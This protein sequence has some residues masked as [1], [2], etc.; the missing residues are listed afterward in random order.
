LSRRKIISGIVFIVA[1]IIIITLSIASGGDG[2]SPVSSTTSYSTGK[3]GFKVF[4]LLLDKMKYRIK[5][6]TRPLGELGNKSGYTSSLLILSPYSF[7]IKKGDS[8]KLIDWAG[9][10]NRILIASKDSNDLLRALDVQVSTNG[11]SILDNPE[12]PLCNN[13]SRLEGLGIARL[14]IKKDYYDTLLKD[15]YGVIC[16]RIKYDRGEINIISAPDI[17]NNSNIKKADNVIFITN[18]INY[19]KIERILVD[20]S[21][22]GIVKGGQKLIVP[23]LMWYIL[24]QLIIVILCFYLAMMKRFGKPRKIPADMLRTSTEYIYSFAELFRKAGTQSFV[25]ENSIRGFKRKIAPIIHR[26][27]E[28]PDEKIIE[29]LK[30]MPDIDEGVVSSVLEKTRKAM[31][32]KSMSDTDLLKICG[33]IDGISD[34]ITG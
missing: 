5:R 33:E 9:N 2:R 19:M 29:S 1:I 4:Y 34:E 25:L 28:A 8:G 12:G 32:R 26:S 30:Y 7:L 22:H 27:P 13:V 3:V 11:S 10:G 15:K 18:L 16:A 31:K 24:A 17:F 20:E 21:L 6:F 14:K 23:V